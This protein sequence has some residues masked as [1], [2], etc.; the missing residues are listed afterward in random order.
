[1]DEVLLQKGEAVVCED[2]SADPPEAADTLE[3]TDED[4]IV[5][6]GIAIAGTI[7]NSV[8]V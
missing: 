2:D 3:E 4:V 6:H 8:P 7:V 5:R 1:L